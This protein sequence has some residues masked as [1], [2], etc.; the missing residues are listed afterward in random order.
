MCGA[1]WAGVWESG[2]WRGARAGWCH[3]NAFA[4]GR[5]AKMAMS[6]HVGGCIGS[7]LIY[8][9]KCVRGERE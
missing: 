7:V 1:R 6:S 9:G 3:C 2:E 5:A 8:V 4:M